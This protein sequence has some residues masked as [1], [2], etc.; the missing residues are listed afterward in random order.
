MTVIGERLVTPSSIVFLVVKLRLVPPAHTPAATLAKELDAEETKKAIKGNEEKDL[1]FLNGKKEAEDLD[2][3]NTGG[4]AHAPFWPGVSDLL[5][6]L[7][8]KLIGM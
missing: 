3:G 1:A 7:L 8:P 2:G 4:Y 5:F 6:P